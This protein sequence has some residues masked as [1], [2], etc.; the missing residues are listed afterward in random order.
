[1]KN[2]DIFSLNDEDQKKLLEQK[3]SSNITQKYIIIGFIILFLI[4]ITI[5]IILSVKLSSKSENE[6]EDNDSI[7]YS[8]VVGEI[9]CIFNIENLNKDIFILSNEYQK[10]NNNFDILIN[11]KK[12]KDSKI[13]KFPSNGLNILKYVL[14]GDINMDSMFKNIQQLTSVSMIST[15]NTKI[16]SMISTF[17]ACINLQ[18]FDINGFDYT[19]LKSMRKTFY[20]TN[21]LNLNIKDLKTN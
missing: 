12:I 19:E 4:L 3:S 15:K 10:E 13:Y 9:N 18:S 1:M 16:T 8:K 14:Y 11:N 7:D 17:E 6:T 5:I 20:K 2:D 21:I